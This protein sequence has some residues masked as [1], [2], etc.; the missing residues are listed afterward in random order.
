MSTD[1]PAVSENLIAAAIEAAEKIRDPL[2]GLVEKT[3]IDPSAPFAPDA[4]ERLAALK[5][6]DRAAFEAL[7]AQLKKAG[8]RV[9]ALDQALAEENGDT[10]RRSPTQADI[11]IELAQSAELFHAPDRTGFADLD[12]NGHRETWPI[13]AKGFRRWLARS[14]FAT[15][16]GAPSSEALQSALNVIEAK[17]HFD[18]PERLVNVRVGGL[19]GRL[20]LDL[21][22]E[23]WRAVEIDVTGWRV[24]DNSPVRFRRAAGM[25]PLPM[26]AP[27]GSV[28]TLRSFL[29]VQSDTDFVLIVAW[30]LACLRNRG[31]YPVIVL[32][33]EQGS[34]KSTFSAILRA[35]LDPNTAPLRALPRED[36]DL[37][38]AASNGHVL[39]FDNVS[40]L[41]A[42]ISDTLCRLATGGGFAVRQL[43]TDQDEMLF[44]A[45]RPVILNGIEDIVARPDLA[46]RAMFLTLEPIPE[47][48]RRSEEELWAT[49]EIERPRILGVLLDAVVQGLKR[50][51]GTRL[52][53]LPRM[54]DFAL[55]ATACETALW[56]A[57]T[58]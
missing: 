48:R 50:L 25:Q 58:F 8:S 26:P 41:P 19:D 47:E 42:W 7:R 36:R 3:A 45:V 39:A 38:I 2:D 27:G 56:P 14:F 22:D 28:E 57:G 21:C 40:G 35:L 37:F 18:A 29:N 15:T 51:Q 46:D 30:L 4:V 49:F 11:L 32:S 31:P 20:Y 10:G 23:T 44:D 24:I 55:W 9:A 53:K 6:D 34:A 12:I 13:R 1:N 43:Y 54:A 52:E 33:G 16:Q 5:K 17:A